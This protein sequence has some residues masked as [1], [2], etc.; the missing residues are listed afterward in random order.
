MSTKPMELRVLFFVGCC[1]NL[2]GSLERTLILVNKGNGESIFIFLD[3]LV[4]GMTWFK[5]S[6]RLLH[7]QDE[8]GG[9]YCPGYRLEGEEYNSLG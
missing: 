7:S 3:G 8:A 1:R 5:V 6:D 4:G 9:F 2:G